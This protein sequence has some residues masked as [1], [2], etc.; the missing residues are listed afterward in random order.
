VH[1][2]KKIVEVFLAQKEIGEGHP[3][4][5]PQQSQHEKHE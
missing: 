2:D 3:K 5:T 1:Q 4:D